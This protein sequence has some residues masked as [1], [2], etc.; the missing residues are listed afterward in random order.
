M[1]ASVLTIVRGRSS[2]LANQRLGLLASEMNPHEWIIVGMNEE[3]EIEP[4][5]RLRIRTTRVNGVGD[6][7]PLAEAR[8]RAAEL[9]TTDRL[10]FLDVD[11][12]PSTRMVGRFVKALGESRQLWSGV[13]GYLPAGAC[14][15]DWNE[16]SLRGVATR[17]P[18]QP[19]MRPGQR[20]GSQ[21]YELFW[22]LCFAID[23]DSFNTIGGFDSTYDGYGAEDTDFAFAARAADIPFGYTHAEA[24]HQHHPVCKPPLNHF[25]AIV[26]NARRF[27]QKWGHWAMQSWLRAFDEAGLV[28]FDPVFDRLHVKKRPSEEMVR[29]ATAMTPAGF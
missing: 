19:T 5:E 15:G 23:R 12:I 16:E 13:V 7:L 1:S 9:A 6:E 14:D 10:I 20:I 17:H 2:H 11:C 18:I 26:R 27:H 21:R 22:S 8:N 4:D 3:V 25:D 28:E 24:F 29:E